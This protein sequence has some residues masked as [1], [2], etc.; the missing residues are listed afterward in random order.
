MD[1]IL[2]EFKCPITLDVMKD[3]V[4]CEDGFTYERSAILSI[5]NSLSPMTRQPINKNNLIPNRALKNII[6]K[7]LST[8]VE[9][10]NILK[11][12][13]TEEIN[14]SFEHYL[15]K[16]QRELK[17]REEQLIQEKTEYMK[18]KMGTSF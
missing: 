18:Q 6:D 14:I 16:R 11:K 15:R 8:N 10:Q 7:S 3:P 5:K 9:Y 4:L 12:Q 2:D 17:M 1:N 13:K